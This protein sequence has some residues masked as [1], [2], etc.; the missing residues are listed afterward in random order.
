RDHDLTA[1]GAQ[2]APPPDS[3]RAA[4]G[5][6][7][8]STNPFSM[9][10]GSP[11]LSLIAVMMLLLNIVNT[12]NEWIMDKVLSPEKLDKA[13]VTAFYADFYLYQNALT[14]LI[15]LFVTSRVQRNFGARAAL[16]FE[17]TVDILGGLVFFI[18]PILPVIR[19]HKILENSIDYSIQ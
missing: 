5:Q 1:R 10:M 6:A 18:A 11:Y 15:Q 14:F 9:V 8:K 2:T 4:P 19:W 16:M 12:N 3:S 13:G 7:K 17:P